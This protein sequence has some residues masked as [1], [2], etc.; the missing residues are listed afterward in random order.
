MVYHPILVVGH[1]QMRVSGLRSLEDVYGG[2]GGAPHCIMGAASML[3]ASA[4]ALKTITMDEGV[5]MG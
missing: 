3:K 5:T 1:L 4:S 2:C